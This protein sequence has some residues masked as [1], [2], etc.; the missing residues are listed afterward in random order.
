MSNSSYE[1]SFNNPVPEVIKENIKLEEAADFGSHKNVLQPKK[2]VKKK[3]IY[4]FT[5][6][7]KIGTGASSEVYLVYYNRNMKLY[8]LKVISKKFLSDSRG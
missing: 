4:D 5:V 1:S 3:T 7:A 2:Y 8:A 6:L